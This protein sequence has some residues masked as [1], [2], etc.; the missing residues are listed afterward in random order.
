MA[1]TSTLSSP[2]LE[3]ESPEEDQEPASSE[4]SRESARKKLSNGSL[5]NWVEPS[6]EHGENP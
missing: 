2:E 4:T 3:R 6:S 1:W 5:S